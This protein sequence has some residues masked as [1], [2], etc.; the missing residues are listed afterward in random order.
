[1]EKRIAPQRPDR[2]ERTWTSIWEEDFCASPRRG[3]RAETGTG[4]APGAGSLLEVKFVFENFN[5]SQCKNSRADDFVFESL[6]G[7][8]AT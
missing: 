1:M 4:A 8:C 3:G 5:L 6:T 7:G 2:I